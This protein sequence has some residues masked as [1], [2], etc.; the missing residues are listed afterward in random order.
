MIPKV[1]KELIQ[2]ICEQCNREPENYVEKGLTEMEEEGQEAIANAI[3][4][5]AQVCA[6]EI[7]NKF[8]HD[9]EGG[10]V[11]YIKELKIDSE[12]TSEQVL[13]LA[14]IDNKRVIYENIVRIC[15]CLYQSIKQQ[16]I[17]DELNS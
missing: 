2:S 10:I 13:A 1:T 4:D 3:L 6:E 7:E 15:V 12:P 17:V 8:Y 5:T 16:G 14:V 9:I 11:N